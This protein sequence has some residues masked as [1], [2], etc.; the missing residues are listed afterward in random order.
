VILCLDQTL[1]DKFL[2]CIEIRVA[3]I[4]S[5]VETLDKIKTHNYFKDDMPTVNEIMK[6][7]VP[8][9]IASI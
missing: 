9:M 2:N 5:L 8:E 6:G 1:V 3:K 7:K 4:V